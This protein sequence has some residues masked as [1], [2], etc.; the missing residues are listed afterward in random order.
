MTAVV[1]ALAAVQ[2][3]AAKP[4]GMGKFRPEIVTAAFRVQ[5]AA[6][7][8][9][10]AE[11]PGNSAAVLFAGDA[12]AAVGILSVGL[13]SIAQTGKRTAAGIAVRGAAGGTGRMAEA[14]LHVP[15]QGRSG[16]RA[17]CAV[18]FKAAAVGIVV[19]VGGV[20]KFGVAATA[21]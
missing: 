21:G 3:L 12:G 1:V 13:G 20:H 16:I 7:V 15:A 11:P 18:A 19:T 5:A 8:P 2:I 14:V 4:A 6:A 9:V 17:G 10:A